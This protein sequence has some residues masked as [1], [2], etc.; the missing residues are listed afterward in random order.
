MKFL[1]SLKTIWTTCFLTFLIIKCS[2]TTWVA[3]YPFTQKNEGQKVTIKAVSYAP[4][5]ASPMLGVT[6]VYYN[7]KLLYKIDKYY[8]EKILTSDD[9]K[10]LAVIRT[11]YQSVFLSDHSYRPAIEILKNGQPFKILYLNDIIDTTKIL[12]KN[13]FYYWN[14]YFDSDAFRWAKYGCQNCRKDFSSRVLR[15]GD[16]S[17]I[18]EDEWEECKRQC[19]SVKYE[20]LA[21]KISKNSMYVKNNCLIIFTNQGTVIKLDFATFTIQ[22]IPVGVYITQEKSYNA[23]KL[24]RKYKKVKLTNTFEIPNL[25][26]GNNYK[27]EVGNIFGLSISK[28]SNDTTIF[29][30]FIHHIVINKYGKCI[31]FYGNIYDERISKY[32]S[33]QSINKEMTEKLNIWAKEQFFETKLIPKGFECYSFICIVNLK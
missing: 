16:T 4:F 23:P 13:G 5:N 10:Y 12:H 30:V 21:I 7:K 14:Y 17:E 8:R 24:I 3:A 20:K 32:S 11:S 18:D 6:K 19:D 22:Q 31:D 25:T 1:K 15:T 9:G 26:N 28:T 29:N 33:K 27:Q 2:G